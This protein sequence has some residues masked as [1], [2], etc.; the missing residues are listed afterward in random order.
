MLTGLDEDLL[1]EYFLAAD[2]GHHVTAQGQQCR[3]FYP[4]CPM[5]EVSI[6]TSLMNLVAIEDKG[7]AIDEKASEPVNQESE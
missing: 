7:N 3:D 2:R 6:K 5:P 4:E 1:L